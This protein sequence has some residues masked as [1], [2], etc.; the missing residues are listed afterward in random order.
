MNTD[1]KNWNPFKSLRGVR[2]K[3]GAYGNQGPLQSEHCQAPWPEVP[4]LFSRELWKAVEELFPNP[5]AGRAA[6]QRGCSAFG[7]RFQ[8]RIDVVDEGKLLRVTAALP[9]MEREDLKVSVEDNAIVLRG[10]KKDSYRRQRAH[11]RFARTIPMPENAEPEH[12]LAK[13]ADGV[14][15]LT[16]PKSKPARSASRTIDIG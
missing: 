1:P 8:P 12:A 5:F 11:E 6:S 14:L 10:E 15:T 9:G 2:R 13:F 3:S 7:S 16:I 4:R